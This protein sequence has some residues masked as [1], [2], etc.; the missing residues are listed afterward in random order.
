[1]LSKKAAGPASS[2][3]GAACALGQELRDGKRPGGR[4]WEGKR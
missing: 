2:H 4:P 1:M 3:P